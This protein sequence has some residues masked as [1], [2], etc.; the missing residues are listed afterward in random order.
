HR[1]VRVRWHY[2]VGVQ[3]RERAGRQLLLETVSV[4]L[5]QSIWKSDVFHK[6]LFR[7]WKKK[8]CNDFWCPQS[9]EHI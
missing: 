6:N 4:F 7:E 1:T 3:N 5:K 9:D 2:V 8:L